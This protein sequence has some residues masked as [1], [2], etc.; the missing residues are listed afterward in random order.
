M[1]HLQP[2]P[3]LTCKRCVVTWISFS[4]SFTLRLRSTVALSSCCRVRAVSAEVLERAWGVQGGRGGGTTC[5]VPA[6]LLLSNTCTQSVLG[7]SLAP[8]SPL[9]CLPSR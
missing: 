6:R 8:H 3:P 1:K 9:A 7:R 4:V 2:I 5:R